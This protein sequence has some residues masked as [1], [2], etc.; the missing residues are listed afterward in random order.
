MILGFIAT[1]IGAGTALLGAGIGAVAGAIRR[2]REN[3]RLAEENRFNNALFNKERY[4]SPLDRAGFVQARKELE[5]RLDKE[6]AAVKGA[7][8]AMGASAQKAMAKKAA[9]NEAYALAMGQASAQNDQ[10]ID[11]IT[12]RYLQ[13]RDK[14]G[15][16][17]HNI[18]DKDL[19]ALGTASSVTSALGAMIAAS[20]DWAS[21]GKKKVPHHLTEEDYLRETSTT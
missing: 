9:A 6:T 21:T 18:A 12:D 14:L 5:R 13:R 3:E 4:A 8:A 15:D 17:A 2:K 16:L 19:A 11:K 10:Y 1:A 20:G 7:S